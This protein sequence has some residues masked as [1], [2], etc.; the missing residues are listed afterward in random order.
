MRAVF[1]LWGG[2]GRLQS[3]QGLPSMILHGMDGTPHMVD[4]SFTDFNK[5]C[6]LSAV[7]E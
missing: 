7:P 1:P 4:V 5:C 2:L 6:A 3:I